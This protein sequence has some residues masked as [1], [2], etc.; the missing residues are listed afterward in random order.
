VSAVADPAT[1]VAVFDTFGLSGWEVFGGTSASAPIIAA[2][3][4]LAGAPL[5]GDPAAF[6]LYRHFIGRGPTVVPAENVLNDVTT[7]STG[8]CGAPTCDARTGWDGPTGV[9]TPIGTG[10]FVRPFSFGAIVLGN[11]ATLVD[12]SVSV[13]V[14]GTDGALPYTW[15]AGGLPPGLSINPATGVISGVPNTA[16]TFPV[17]ITGR[18]SSPAGAPGVYTFLWTINPS[19]ISTVPNV[20]DDSPG[21]AGTALRA[22]GLVVGTQS[23]VVDCNHLNVVARQIPAAGVQVARGSSVNLTFGRAPAPP[24]VCP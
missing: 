15:A 7:G 4:A 11:Q 18:D 13:T 21:Q 12:T 20:I 23:T 8:D 1:G 3:Y 5:A 10:A 9:G 22:A 6:Y 16:G 24:R 14:R 2:V 17:T 19:T